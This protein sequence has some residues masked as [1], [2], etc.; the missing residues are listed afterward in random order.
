MNN[1]GAV[2]KLVFI[3]AATTHEDHLDRS[4]NAA[5]YCRT[6]TQTELRFSGVKMAYSPPKHEYR[7]A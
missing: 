2:Q 6:E 5:F 4:I 3:D 7:V 1:P